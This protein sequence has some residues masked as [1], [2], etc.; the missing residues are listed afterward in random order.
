[1]R[2]TSS[3]TSLSWIRSEAVTGVNKAA[4]EVGFIHYDEP[5]PM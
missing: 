2:I 5:R 4:F 3:V 1:M